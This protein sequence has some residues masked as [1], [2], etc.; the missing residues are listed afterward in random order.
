MGDI[1]SMRT[2]TP[3]E[4]KMSEIADNLSKYVFEV[5]IGG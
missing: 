4:D 1:K 3:D 5:N 2:E